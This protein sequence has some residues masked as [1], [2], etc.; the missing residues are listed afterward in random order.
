MTV[1]GPGR[2]RIINGH[3]HL[4]GG[5]VLTVVWSRPLP[6]EPSSVRVYQDN[7]GHWYASFVVA[8]E[9]QPLPTTGRVI[10]IDW[11]V[12][13][14]ATTTS[15]IHDYLHPEHGRKA[16]VKLARY[17]RMMARRRPPKGGPA[18]K[19]YQRARRK[20]AKV[21]LKVARQRKD[22]ARKWAKKVARDH[23]AFAVEDFRPRFL[24]R[25]SMARKAADAAA[26]PLGERTYSCTA[27]GAVTPRDKN[28]AYVMLIRAG[29][30]PA[31]VD[32]RRPGH[33]SG[34]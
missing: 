21:H 16:A 8:T 4:A 12:R 30:D 18:S 22:E 33:P 19:G 34:D 23:D 2:F 13:A 31:G 9:S 10:G 6:T 27:C 17:R 25:T 32:R 24:S 5:I 7:L 1:A 28:S 3:L 14:I 26:L 20:A 15:D 29:L 11:G